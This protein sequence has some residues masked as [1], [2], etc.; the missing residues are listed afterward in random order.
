MFDSRFL[1]A[2]P[3]TV[4]IKIGIARRPLARPDPSPVAI[5]VHHHVKRNGF[6]RSS[7]F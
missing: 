7:L 5:I 6:C 2:E 4:G 1:G 3:L